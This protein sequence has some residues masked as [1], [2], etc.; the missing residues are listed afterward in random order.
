MQ[1]RQSKRSRT[2][3]KEHHLK[4]LPETSPPQPASV[5]AV[6]S[7]STLFREVLKFLT[8]AEQRR[9]ECFSKQFRHACDH[10][11]LWQAV[12]WQ[13]PQLSFG[14]DPF[15]KS[16]LATL[17]RCARFGTKQLRFTIKTLLCVSN[18]IKNSVHLPAVEKLVITAPLGMQSIA[19]LATWTKKWNNNRTTY[20]VFSENCPVVDDLI[21]TLD[22]EF[23][24]DPRVEFPD[25]SIQWPDKHDKQ[26]CCSVAR[27][28]RCFVCKKLDDKEPHLLYHSTDCK[29]HGHH[30]WDEWLDSKHCDACQ[31]SICS[32]CVSTNKQVSEMFK[33]DCDNQETYC[34]PCFPHNTEPCRDCKKPVIV[35]GHASCSDCE[36]PLC[37]Q[38][39]GEEGR[40]KTCR[41]LNNSDDDD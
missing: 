28:G 20:I 3:K 35:S 32:N 33:H 30:R 36:N 14:L 7:L 2:E 40:C 8:F 1:G 37:N 10:A 39:Q 19:D 25:G 29:D 9:S 26:R 6:F 34:I 5:D 31:R 22:Q 4:P 38:C 24:D 15:R 23:G 21:P 12:D 18:E 13:L 27:M 16:V 17:Q 11:A 41:L